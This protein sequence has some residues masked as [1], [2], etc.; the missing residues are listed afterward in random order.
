MLRIY[1]GNRIKKGKE[2]FKVRV[3]AIDSLIE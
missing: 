1:K 3:K 2:I